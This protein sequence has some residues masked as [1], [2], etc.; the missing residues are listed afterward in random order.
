[1]SYTATPKHEDMA[2]SRRQ[3]DRPGNLYTRKDEGREQ[4]SLFL[5][6]LPGEWLWQIILRGA[7]D[8]FWRKNYSVITQ[9]FCCEIQ[10]HCPGEG[11]AGT[12]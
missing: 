4:S 12:T 8:P 7:K 2:R 3:S 6:N 5:V 1:M 11:T 9:H 10:M